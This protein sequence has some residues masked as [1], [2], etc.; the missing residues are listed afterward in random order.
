MD[1]ATLL[2]RFW[3]FYIIIIAAMLILRPSTKKRLMA[4][5]DNQTG[6][7]L[8]GFMA[9]LIGLFSLTFYNEWNSDIT[10]LPTIFGYAALFKGISMIAY[11][12]FTNN[13]VKWADVKLFPV[14]MLILLFLG[15]AL[16]YYGGEFF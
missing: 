13:V 12:E 9:L 15:F 5:T 10:V 1:N 6:L 11:P 14:Y 8:M 7:M 4:L 2:I 3:A 16:L